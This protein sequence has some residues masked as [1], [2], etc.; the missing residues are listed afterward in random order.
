M[1]VLVTGATGYVGSR[2][3]P[4]LLED[5]HT[6]V[7]ATRGSLIDSFPWGDEVEVA[8][9]DIE[10][11]GTVRTAMRDVEAVIYLVHS[12]DSGED[13]VEKDRA[14]AEL[15]AQAAA[16][17]GVARLVYLS[18]LIPDD[19]LSDHLK[20]RLQVEEVFLD[21][22]VPSV[23]LRAAMV[24]GGGSMSFELLR[25]MS[26]RVPF[27]PIPGWMKSRLQPI[28][29]ADVVE[30]V[31]GALR[32]APRN[33]AYDVGGAEVVTYPELLATFA[34]VD[35]L[36]RIQFT[37]PWVPRVVVGLIVSWISRMPRSEVV[38][39][40]ESL[41]HD[42]VCHDDDAD[43]DLLPDGYAHVPLAEA[44]RRSLRTDSE[45]ADH[46]GDIEATAPTDS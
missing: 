8:T 5:G 39:L 31:A 23:S 15:V 20:S 35:G 12:M 46:A 26:E 6:V 3:V 9:F 7:A 33:R 18:G 41:S 10:D 34:E 45:A 43:H 27:T 40:V 36:R 19:D 14:A 44:L 16:D 28:A 24:I 42:M 38:A 2:V 25:R 1:R 37:V 11:A 29:V 4:R 13:F 30:L 32:G 17:A 21:S 22:P